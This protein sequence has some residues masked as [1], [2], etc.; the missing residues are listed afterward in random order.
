MYWFLDFRLKN[1]TLCINF[2]VAEKIETKIVSI[3][4]HLGNYVL[5]RLLSMYL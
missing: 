4:P 3:S 2:P 5:I 1:V